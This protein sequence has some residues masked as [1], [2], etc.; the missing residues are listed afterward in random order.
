ML[1]HETGDVVGNVFPSE[2]FTVIGVTKVSAIEDVD[3]SLMN[4]FVFW[5][6]EK[7]KP[8]FCLIE[9]FGEEDKSG[10]VRRG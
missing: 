8:I 1:V 5:S 7:L 3:I 6:S 10:T 2:S 4:Y 9:Y